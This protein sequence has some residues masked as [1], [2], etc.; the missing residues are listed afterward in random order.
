MAVLGHTRYSQLT[1][2]Y[3][4]ELDD[5]TLKSS[6]PCL[7][8]TIERDSTRCLVFKLEDIIKSAK[9]NDQEYEEMAKTGAIIEITIDWK[10]HK[11]FYRSF[12]SSQDCKVEHSF[13]RSDSQDINVEYAP[14]LKR[15][16]SF[17]NDHKFRTVRFYYLL[18]LVVIPRAKLTKMTINFYGF[19]TECFAYTGL[20]LFIFWL[21]KKFVR[22]R[23]KTFTDKLDEVLKIGQDK[24]EVSN[25]STNH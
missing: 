1:I 24:K 9:N 3:S 17:S 25:Q 4:I 19:A 6:R 16:T 20:F 23:V 13:S 5:Y 10:C 15:V 14:I 21:F 8:N 22:S 18:K 12:D 2:F 11:P 7:S